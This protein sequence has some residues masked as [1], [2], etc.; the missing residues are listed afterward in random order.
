MLPLLWKDIRLNRYVLAMA[1]F[2]VD[3][4]YLTTVLFLSAFTG[5]PETNTSVSERLSIAFPFSLLF[6]ALISAFIGGY[7]IAAEKSERTDRFLDYLPPTR[8]AIVSSKVLVAIGLLLLAWAI[9]ALVYLAGIKHLAM[10]SGILRYAISASLILFGLAWL[11][12]L[13][14]RSSTL[15][16]LAAIVGAIFLLIVVRRITFALFGSH[17]DNKVMMSIMLWASVA[18]A[19]ATV[20][21][22]FGLFL[23]KPAD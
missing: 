21:A 6:L 3:T 20:L 16:G 12:S 11:L 2:V 5:E 13:Y 23:R 1:V 17:V 18:G 10:T 9:P 19:I 4:P 22:G 14:V 15:S 8:L 7:P